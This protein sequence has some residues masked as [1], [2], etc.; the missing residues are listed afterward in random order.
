MV[1]Y[2]LERFHSIGENPVC[3][4][5]GILDPLILDEMPDGKIPRVSPLTYSRNYI[6]RLDGQ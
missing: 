1:F 6:P 5:E 3:F 4:T 2:T